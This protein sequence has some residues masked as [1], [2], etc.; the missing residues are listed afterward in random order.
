MVI[1]ED[2]E[3]TTMAVGG[4]GNYGNHGMGKPTEKDTN[5]IVSNTR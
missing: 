2:E 4:Q 5:K 1:G 3:M